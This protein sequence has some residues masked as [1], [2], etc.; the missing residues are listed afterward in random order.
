MI[1]RTLSA[2]FPGDTWVSINIWTQENA[3]L[4]LS[5]LLHCGE[6]DP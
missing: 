4:T 2:H 5:S 1:D 3:K 6:A